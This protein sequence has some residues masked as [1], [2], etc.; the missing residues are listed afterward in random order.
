MEGLKTECTLPG[1]RYSRYETPVAPL[2]TL[3]TTAALGW[4]A[5]LSRHAG[6][7]WINRR[8]VVLC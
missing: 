1:M 6:Y 7:T 8:I 5:S 4:G 2:G 3:G